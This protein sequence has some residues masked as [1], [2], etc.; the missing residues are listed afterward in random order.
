VFHILS[1]KPMQVIWDV[2]LVVFWVVFDVL[3]CCYVCTIG[4]TW[5]LALELKALWLFKMSV[6]TH[7]VTQPDISAGLN[8]HV[9][10]SQMWRSAVMSLPHDLCSV[11]WVMRITKWNLCI[12]SMYRMQTLIEHCTWRPLHWSL[13]T[14]AHTGHVLQ[15][16]TLSGHWCKGF[17]LSEMWCCVVWAA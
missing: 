2:T 7:P 4:C 6:S 13:V 3:K 14:V 15:T 12:L 16:V 17:R 1:F 11:W 8:F 10:S 5:T 9:C